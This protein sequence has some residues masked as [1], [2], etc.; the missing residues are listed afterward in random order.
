VHAHTSTNAGR[1][2][3][4]RNEG[5]HRA[6]SQWPEAH[7]WLG[8]GALAVGFGAAL[9]SGSGVAYADADSHSPDAPSTADVSGPSGK[10]SSSGNAASNTAEPTGAATHANLSSSDSEFGADTTH[11]SLPAAT[12]T[13]TATTTSP[14]TAISF[15]G[16]SDPFDGTG[17]VSWSGLPANGNVANGVLTMP[18]TSSYPVVE[19]STP[20]NLEGQSASVQLTSTPNTVASSTQAFFQLHQAGTPQNFMGWMWTADN[21][22]SAEL[23][24]GGR[25]TRLGTVAYTPNTQWLRIAENTG[26]LTWQTSADGTTWTTQASTA[27]SSISGAVPRRLYS[28]L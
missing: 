4:Q 13:T 20:I 12:T 24:V 27:D 9:T 1:S 10:N 2:T 25:A 11:A 3:K 7:R 8:A 14:S 18:T 28:W 15:V 17:N 26:T 5:K 19:A 6:K 23:S 21:T 22:L 16:L